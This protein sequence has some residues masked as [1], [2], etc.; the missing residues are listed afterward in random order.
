MIDIRNVII[1][2]IKNELI[3]TK[4]YKGN[5]NPK[6][7][8]NTNMVSLLSEM[9]CHYVNENKSTKDNSYSYTYEGVPIEIDDNMKPYTF[10]CR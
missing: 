2:E 10:E 5:D 4:R 8:M 9:F 6:F 7:Y 1:N 3:Y